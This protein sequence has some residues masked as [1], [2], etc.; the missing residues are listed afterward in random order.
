M[1]LQASPRNRS[2]HLIDLPL[3]HRIPGETLGA[4]L[5]KAWICLGNVRF[6]ATGAFFPANSG[7]VENFLAFETLL[8]IAGNHSA[9][10]L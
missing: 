7:D 5:S 10:Q 3:D 2:L 4:A 6:A 9:L 1:K 8:E